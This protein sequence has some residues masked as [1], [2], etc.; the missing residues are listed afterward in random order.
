MN[1][2]EFRKLFGKKLNFLRKQQG[3]TQ[4]ELAEKLNYSDKAVSKWER[5]ESIPDFFTV[6]KIANFF[7]VS[8]EELI[9]D[10]YDLGSQKNSVNNKQRS[11]R[12][13]VP[14]I[15]MFTVF[16]IASVVFF[17][18]KNVPAWSDYAYFPFV[19]SV[20]IASVVMIVFSSIWWHW[21]LKCVCVSAL[22]W[23][24]A[25]ALYCSVDIESIKYI[26]VICGVMQA[27][28]ILS[29]LFRHF[30]TKK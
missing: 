7:D 9:S 24:G 16:F 29:Y 8:M 10:D 28:C 5:G 11:I 25:V 26:F 12:L 4:S 6:H 27:V 1:E 21:I 30:F 14:L 15:S 18:M 19:Y 22:I 13:F 3:I 20:P 2:L 23:S 17:I